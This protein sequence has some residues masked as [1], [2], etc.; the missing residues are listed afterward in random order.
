M[1][2]K[3][4]EWKKSTGFRIGPVSEWFS[5]SMGILYIPTY[6]SPFIPEGY[7]RNLRYFSK[8][9]TFYQYYLAMSNTADM[10]GGKPIAVCP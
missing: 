5:I 7:Q 1:E 2:Y 6:H 3:T 8:K 10:T 9:P 4:I